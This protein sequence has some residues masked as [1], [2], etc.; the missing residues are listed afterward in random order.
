V[1]DGAAVLVGGAIGTSARLGIDVLVPHGDRGFPFSTLLI[2][3]VGA[4]ALGVLIARLWPSASS[5]VKAGLGAGLLG[6]FTTFS[7]LAVSLVALGSAGDWPTA[8]VYLTLSLALGL[9]AA[10]L[11]LR[12]G[13][14][15]RQPIDMVDE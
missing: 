3:V 4:F 15:P 14:A 8:V 1:F 7:A 2:N 6:S 10:A 5:W 11:G 13:R 9:G 12:L